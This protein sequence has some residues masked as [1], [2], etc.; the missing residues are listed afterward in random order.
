[1]VIYANE[2]ATKEK[3]KLSEIQISYN[4]ILLYFSFV[5]LFAWM[6]GDLF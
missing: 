4:I 5:C 6:E 1:M 2:V 3:E